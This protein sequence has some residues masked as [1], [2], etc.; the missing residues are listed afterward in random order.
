MGRKKKTPEISPELLQ[1]TIE[2]VLEEKG[3][4]LEKKSDEITFERALRLYKLK[5]PHRAQYMKDK[6]IILMFIQKYISP[7]VS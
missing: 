7:N 6:A 1:K 2:A 3:I 4:A 5:V